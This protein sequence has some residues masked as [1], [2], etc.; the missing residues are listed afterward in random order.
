MVPLNTIFWALVLLFGLIGALRGW[1]KEIMVTS[2]VLLAMF[3]Q[4]VF[5]QYVLG[6]G[7]PY[8]PML[9]PAP[10]DTGPVAAYTETQYYLVTGLLLLLVFSG[11]AGPALVSRFSAKIAREKL[12]D[13]LLGFFLGL[14]NGYLIIGMLWYH[15]DRSGYVIGA[16][17]A[18]RQGSPAWV[19][20]N[21]Y[22]L[23]NLIT[24][25]VLYVLIAI[26]FVFVIIVFI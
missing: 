7:N 21:Q 26:A 16:I 9:F 18:P 4:Q 2:S 22:L 15:L 10:G 12:Q 13:A 17:E 19:I 5:G 11:Y 8:L 24:P 25:G 20:A 3:V 14:L 6:P 23:P 1:A